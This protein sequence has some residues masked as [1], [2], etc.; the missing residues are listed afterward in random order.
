MFSTATAA[1]AGRGTPAAAGGW[2]IRPVGTGLSDPAPPPPPAPDTSAMSVARA[3]GNLVAPDELPRPAPVRVDISGLSMAA[4]GTEV[5]KESERRQVT[6]VTVDL[7]GI[8]MAEVGA[9]LDELR[10]EKT[11]VNP[12]ISHIKL[13]D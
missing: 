6:P 8:S 13:A 4:A 9:P 3:G 11:L 7:S 1:S 2:D 5:L 12:D 10:E